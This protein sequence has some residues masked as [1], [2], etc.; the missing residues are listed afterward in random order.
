MAKRNGRLI[1]S[2]VSIGAVLLGMI[3]G[4]VYGYGKMGQKQEGQKEK[5]QVV[6]TEG[7]LPSRLNRGSIGVIESQLKSID[8]RLDTLNTQQQAGFQAVMEKLNE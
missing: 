3:V 1:L 2:G 4:V 5:L 8:G 6:K 7:C